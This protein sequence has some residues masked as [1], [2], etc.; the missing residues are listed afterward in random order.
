MKRI[1]CIIIT[2]ICFFGCDTPGIDKSDHSVQP[3]IP[4]CEQMFLKGNVK[5]VHDIIVSD[6]STNTE[7][8]AFDRSGKI[9]TCLLNGEEWELYADFRWSMFPWIAGTYANF[10]FPN[11]WTEYD[12]RTETRTVSI[13]ENGIVTREVEK[14]IEYEWDRS[15]GR[16][17][18]VRCYIN[19]EPVPL[20]GIENGY[21]IEEYLYYSNGLPHHDFNFAEEEPHL[22]TELSYDEFDRNGNPLNIMVHTPNGNVTIIR[23][24]EYYQ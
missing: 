23:Q 19:N 13:T 1:V 21:A 16:F 5:A 20:A 11:D 14:K 8:Y 15:S 10:V 22:Y 6:Y 9:E 12:S 4:M 24:I 3:E 17:T 7:S 18:K 2:V